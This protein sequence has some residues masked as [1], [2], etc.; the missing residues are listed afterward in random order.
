ML[1]I[2]LWETSSGEAGAAYS[3]GPQKDIIL[4]W[5]Y[6]VLHGSDGTTETLFS[7]ALVFH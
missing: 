6:M 7:S 3:V 1:I 5:F 2:S 4:L